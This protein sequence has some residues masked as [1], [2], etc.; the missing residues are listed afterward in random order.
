MKEAVAMV[1]CLVVFGCG[2]ERKI[3]AM[4]DECE[5]IAPISTNVPKVDASICRCGSHGDVLNLKMDGG[6]AELFWNWEP[7]AEGAT[8]ITEVL[9]ERTG[10]L[11]V[12]LRVW[13]APGT[14]FSEVR[15]R[16]KEA[17]L[18][19]VSKVELAVK[20]GGNGT[21][22]SLLP[23]DIPVMGG[24]L[25]ME[26]CGLM[27][28]LQ[29]DGGFLI[30]DESGTDE[31]RYSRE[32]L[33]L[34]LDLWR[35]VAEMSQA[36]LVVNLAVDCGVKHGMLCEVLS[37]L[38]QQVGYVFLVEYEREVKVQSPQP[39]PVPPVGPESFPSIPRYQ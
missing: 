35:S 38:R 23:I 1:L 7:L 13:A 34:R 31:F 17:L 30:R 26:L 27:M 24:D 33:S 12:T 16:I 15:G 2:E 3:Q 6:R 28:R 9:K 22:I 32:V 11:A 21:S 4:L 19:G 5:M 39:M 25:R 29:S 36:E 37:I 10:V 14:S 8:S 20:H 18:A